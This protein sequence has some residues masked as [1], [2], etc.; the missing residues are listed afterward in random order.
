MQPLSLFRDDRGAT[1]IIVAAGMVL[2]LGMAALAIDIGFGFNE[3]RQDQTS[4]DSGV[5]AGAV[6]AIN[7]GAAVRTQTLDYVRKNLP[8]TYT[9]AEWQAGWQGCVDPAADRNAGGFNFV[10][11][12]PPAGWSVTD[13]ANWCISFESARGLLRVR[14]PDQL[15]ET[16][17]A[18]V[19]GVD[20]LRTHATAVSKVSFAGEGGI[21]PFGIPFGSGAGGHLCLSSGPTGQA[22]DACEGP[23]T[24][25]FGTLKGRMFGNPDIPTATNCTASPLASVLAINIAAGY[26]HIVVADQD[27]AVGNEVRDQCFNPFVDT[28]NT[29]TGFPGN[30]AET[31]LVGPMSGYTPRLLQSST[32]ASVFGRNVDNRPLWGYLSTSPDYGGGAT[33]TPND[34]APAICAPSTFTSGSTMDWDGNGSIDRDRSWQHMQACLAAYVSGSFSAVMF[35]PSLGDNAARFGY[36][37]EFWESSLGTGNSWLHVYRFRAVYLETTTWKKGGT[38]IFHSPGEPCVDGSE[39][40]APCVGGG[41]AMRQLSSFVIPDAA[42]PLELRGTTPPGGT[43]LNPFGAELYD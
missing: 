12:P 36:V 24:G 29:D 9:N 37:P 43:G 5:M 10:A 20:E 34:D 23:V 27:G 26:D 42:L 32:T 31:G 15:I 6:E 8:T 11:L 30:G 4:A 17:F 38:F 14:V 41:Y 19:I 39:M 21:L 3:R 35:R 40:P 7:G 33:A 1:A 16:S 18:A 28:L 25:N 13:P 22:A 2:F